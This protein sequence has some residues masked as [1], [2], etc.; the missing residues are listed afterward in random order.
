[1]ALTHDKTVHTIAG[2]RGTGEV[3]AYQNEINAKH[4]VA[5]EVYAAMH[6]DTKN[7]AAPHV[8]SNPHG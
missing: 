3:A 8:S 7:S 6:A 4:P 1:M 2:S 5:L